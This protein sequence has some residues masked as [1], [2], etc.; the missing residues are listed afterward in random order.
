LKHTLVFF[1]VSIFSV[2]IFANTKQVA[3]CLGATNPAKSYGFEINNNIFLPF[4][5]E[6]EPIVTTT[7]PIISKR[8]PGVKINL[9]THRKFKNQTKQFL[10][11]Y[12]IGNVNLIHTPFHPPLFLRDAWLSRKSNGNIGLYSLPENPYQRNYI[13]LTKLVSGTCVAPIIND[14]TGLTGSSKSDGGNLL[15]ID[16]SHIL[17]N[18]AA[19]AKN[20]IK[21]VEAKD[22]EALQTFPEFKNKS[23]FEKLKSET[24]GFYRFLSQLKLHG[25]KIHEFDIRAGNF[26]VWHIDESFAFIRNTQ[27]GSS[28]PIS[29]LSS[30]PALGL[31]LL[32]GLEKDK[33]ISIEKL[34]STNQFLESNIKDSLDKL[35]TISKNVFKCKAIKVIR[36]PVLY[37]GLYG[38]SLSLGGVD[39]NI[40]NGIYLESDGNRTFVYPKANFTAWNRYFEE[41]MKALGVFAI[42]VDAT[43]IQNKR[44][45][46]H[47]LTNQI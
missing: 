11:D 41:Q 1:I 27:K 24:H 19:F 2:S 28:C 5:A 35:R 16:Q 38:K 36:V 31:R 43:S 33:K 10:K 30:S 7:L 46:L 44:G 15:R 13:E 40:L 8:H 3:T 4:T 6:S 45:G 17:T 12:K 9:I 39:S 23:V 18:G 20:T 42:G 32:D 37:K 22:I 26:N 14:V 29:I 47:C 25:E 21:A 34:K